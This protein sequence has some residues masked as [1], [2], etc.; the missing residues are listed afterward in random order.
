[1][2]R[3]DVKVVNWRELEGMAVVA[4]PSRSRELLNCLANGSCRIENAI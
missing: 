3:G 4:L 1:M 2:V